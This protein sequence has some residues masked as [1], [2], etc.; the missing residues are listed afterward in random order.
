MNNCN[1][2]SCVSIE[3]PVVNAVTF[4]TGPRG[5]GIRSITQQDNTIT[6]T[7]DDGREQVFLLPDWWFGTREE[8]NMLSDAEKSEKSLYF[9]EEGS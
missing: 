4:P 8:F 9:I 6:V 1:N 2:H 5:T 7:Y 3:P